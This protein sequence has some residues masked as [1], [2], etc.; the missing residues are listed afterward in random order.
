[1]LRIA[2]ADARPHA[3]SSKRLTS[4]QY[5]QIYPD[6]IPRVFSLIFKNNSFKFV[7]RPVAYAFVRKFGAIRIVEENFAPVY[8]YDE[9]PVQDDLDLASIAHLR[10]LLSQNEIPFVGLIRAAMTDRLRTLLSPFGMPVI[11][12]E[13]DPAA[14]ASVTGA[15]IPKPHKKKNKPSLRRISPKE[16]SKDAALA[17]PPEAAKPVTRN[18][19]P[20]TRNP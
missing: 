4:D 1:M 19:E 18:P 16:K 11:L 14:F 5:R 6:R 13:P 7:E 2:D 15:G 10:L 3:P 20:V 9:V 8:A 12:T 17:S